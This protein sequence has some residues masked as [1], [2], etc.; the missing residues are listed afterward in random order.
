M[1]ATL[2]I[3]H[4][5]LGEGTPKIIV[6]IVGKTAQEILPAAQ[7]IAAHPHADLVEWRADHYEHALNVEETCAMLQSL[8]AVLEDKP[9]LYTFR[10]APE[11][12]KKA[13]EAAQYTALCGT[14]AASGQADLIDV[15][16][17]SPAA[18]ACVHGIHAHHVPVVGSWHDFTQTPAERDLLSRFRA[19]QQE[20]AD[21]LKIAVMP[22]CL[23]DV[24]HLISAAKAMHKEALKPLCAMSMGDT[25]RITRTHCQHFGGCM[26]FG[27]L[28]TASAPGQVDV[29]TLYAVLREGC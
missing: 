9:L 8:R 15:E 10:T 11:G 19:M 24:T 20:G 23:E 6:P 17:F 26:T 12:G 13:I 18:D 27:A 7:A 21:V 4:L 14:V 28:G 25:G 16:M 3:R 2:T 1:A 29:D 22:Q 5:T